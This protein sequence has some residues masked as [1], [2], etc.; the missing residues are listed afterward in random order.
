MDWTEAINPQGLPLRLNSRPDATTW[1]QSIAEF[2][3]LI[4]TMQHRL[5]QFAFLRLHSTA[6]AEDVVQEVFLQAYRDRERHKA[7]GNVCPFLYRMVANRCIDLQRKRRRAAGPLEEAV[8][9]PSAGPV[10]NNRQREIEAWLGRLPSRQAEVIRLRVYADLPFDAVAQ[11][12]G[13][14]VPTVKSRFRYGIQKLRRIL[15][16]EGGER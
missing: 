10:E 6:D 7:V 4:E 16:R 15:K 11:S 13:C 5:V 9:E 12:L 3:A 14:S 8:A 2:D 1:P